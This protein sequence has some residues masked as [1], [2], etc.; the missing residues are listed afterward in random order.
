[1]MNIH[2]LFPVTVLEDMNHDH[3]AIKQSFEENILKYTDSN[4]MSDE[5][6]G[7]VTMHHEPAF[8]PMFNS[9]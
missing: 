6:T 1:M 2:L 8:E 9:N 4:G 7:H 5:S 3:Q